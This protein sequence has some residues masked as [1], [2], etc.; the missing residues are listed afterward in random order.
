MSVPYVYVIKIAFEIDIF[1]YISSR[2]SCYDLLTT[3]RSVYHATII[4]WRQNQL[5]KLSLL[6]VLKHWKWKWKDKFY[7]FNYQIPLNREYDIKYN[8]SRCFFVCV[9]VERRGV[10]R[11]YQYITFLITIHLRKRQKTW[12]GCL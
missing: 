12:I 3:C 7:R 10:Y 4:Y 1:I 8:D 11:F 9:R 5:L 6:L 2:G